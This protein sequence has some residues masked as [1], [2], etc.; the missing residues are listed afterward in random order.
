[1][2]FRGGFRL[3]LIAGEKECVQNLGALRRGNIQHWHDVHDETPFF[4]SKEA[5]DENKADRRSNK[6]SDT[7][8]VI[9]PVW[10]KYICE[11]KE[12]RKE[13]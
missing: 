13:C 6:R 9:K 11:H 3:I 12:A 5:H 2:L 4:V 1:M 8:V 7:E 10:D